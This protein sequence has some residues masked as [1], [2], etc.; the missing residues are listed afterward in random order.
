M[1]KVSPLM[2]LP[3][4]GRMASTKDCPVSPAVGLEMADGLCHGLS[5][6]NGLVSSTS[7]QEKSRSA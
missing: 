7:S 4:M 5:I 1:S 3:A 2:V 6:G